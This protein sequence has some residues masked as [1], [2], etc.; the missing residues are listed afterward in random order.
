MKYHI[1]KDWAQLYRMANQ[2]PLALTVLNTSSIEMSNPIEFLGIQKWICINETE[3]A[4]QN[5]TIGNMDS[6]LAQHSCIFEEDDINMIKTMYEIYVHESDPGYLIKPENNSN[7][8]AYHSIKM[9]PNPAGEFLYL[10]SHHTEIIKSVTITDLMGRVILTETFSNQQ[11]FQNISLTSLAEGHYMVKIVLNNGNV[12][13]R[14]L[15]VI[16]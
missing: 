12:E 15:V 16:K 3:L 2:R 7:I 6:V 14:K 11:F 1:A 10:E 4:L 13:Q 9:Y 8:V 5:D